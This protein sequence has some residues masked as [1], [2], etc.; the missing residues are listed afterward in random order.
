[1]E[2]IVVGVDE[3]NTAAEA[4][5]WAIREREIR[6]GSLTAVLAWSYLAQHHVTDGD[7]FRPE[8]GQP[9]AEAALDDIVERAAPADAASVERQAV[10][11]LPVPA[12]LEASFDADLLVLGAR[13][14][15]G[16]KGLLLGS[17]SQQCVQHSK[18]PVAIVRDGATTADRPERVVVGIDGSPT[19]QRALRWAADEAAARDASLVVVHAWQPVVVPAGMPLPGG[20]DAEAIREAAQRMVDEQIGDLAGASRA[21]PV[22]IAIVCD[23]AA[24]AVL[25]AA[26]DASLVVVGSRGRGGFKGLLLGSVSSQIV[27]HAPCPVVVVP[28]EATP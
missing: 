3:S 17:V 8:Y 2:R 23:V 25:E 24:R 14:L 15:G 18:V 11:D 6:G 20:T 28:P 21:V 10:C 26:A 5:R 13:G 4:L 27:H 19:S 12:L 1:M 16:F 22:E 7:A 9:Q